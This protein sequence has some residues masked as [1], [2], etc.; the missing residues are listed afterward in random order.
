MTK[1]QTIMLLPISP[2][3]LDICRFAERGAYF[4]F[5]PQLIHAMDKERY[6]D[7]TM[8]TLRIIV[9]SLRLVIILTDIVNIKGNLRLTEQLENY[10]LR[11]HV[12]DN[13]QNHCFT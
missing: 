2:D 13:L 10:K 12:V 8:Y 4:L 7:W 3:R 5:H 1:L 9:N 11:L 6:K